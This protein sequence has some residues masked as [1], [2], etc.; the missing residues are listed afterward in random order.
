MSAG[1][2]R[3]LS[4]WG[5]TAPT[6][7]RVHRPADAA[8]AVALAERADGRGVLARGLGRAYGDAAQNAG[9]EV[10]EATG[11][12][13]LG[14]VDAERGT[15][16]VGA[17]V[18]IEA[19][20]RAVV[21][22]GWF[23]PVTPGTAHVTVGGAIACDVHGKNHH[24][25][26]SFSAHVEDLEL[27][28]PAG[29]VRTVRPGD[30][31]FAAT[32]G[33]MGLTGIV[34]A[35]TLRLLRVR[36]AT[37]RVDVER[38]GDLDD[39]LGRMAARDDEYRYSVAWIDCLARGRALGRSILLRGDHA[40]PDEL[41]PRRRSE[42]LR[43][44][45]TARVGAPRWV[46]GGLLRPLTVRAFNELW[47]RRAPREERGRLESI[48]AFFHPLDALRDWN[49]LYGPRGFVQY[50]LVVPPGR[51]DALRAA[52]ERLSR[53]GAPSF[54][55]V[56]KRFG[57][58]GGGLSFPIEGW[59][60]ALDVP[61]AVPG[62]GALLDGLDELVASA[63]GRVY[64]GKDARLRPDLLE[65]MYPDLPRWR[66]A[67]ARLDPAGALRSDLGRRLALA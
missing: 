57:P 4:G 1:E 46:P 6:L 35:A 36:T 10:V 18:S 53:A 34:L 48:P 27:W 16:R 44:A 31:A 7:A 45:P 32:A 30:E 52:I 23:V 3:L 62:L 54:L 26:A 11:L 66:A 5:R 47:Y 42:P 43:Y 25:D 14:P 40:E 41:P 12:T 28:S 13:A 15:V 51:E 49:R 50:Q 9:G 21:P 56:L 59:T 2:P 33:G 22:Q 63:G 60:L 64:L 61:A 55:A 37:V 38:A 67:R 20:L 29:G 17:G 19:L 8:E 58:G 24:R 65:A 39:A